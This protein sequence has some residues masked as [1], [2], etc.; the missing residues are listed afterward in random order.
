[1]SERCI[2]SPSDSSVVEEALQWRGSK[3]MLR[4]QCNLLR[5]EQRALG[6]LKWIYG[7]CKSVVK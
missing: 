4:D 6:W 1:M 3:T 7:D 2:R 5:N